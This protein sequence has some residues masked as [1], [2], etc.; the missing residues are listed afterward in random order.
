MISRQR[1]PT[2]TSIWLEQA[3]LSQM[4]TKAAASSNETGG[5]LIGART[6]HALLITDI[7]E[8]PTKN[9]HPTHY[10]L[11][12]DAANNALTSYLNGLPVVLLMGYIGSWHSHPG[13]SRPSG[14]DTASLRNDARFQQ[15]TVALIVISSTSEAQTA[16]ACA[17]TRIDRPQIVHRLHD[18]LRS[19][20][21]RT[22]RR[23]R[24]PPTL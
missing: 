9:P 2:I 13:S 15:D 7:I 23:L 3:L 4:R 24:E 22:P 17:K 14:P 16:R 1:T 12:T 8:I 11:S 21:P 19:R 6:T 10:T 18:A 5:I 20:D